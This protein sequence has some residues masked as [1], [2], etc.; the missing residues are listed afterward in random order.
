MARVFK[1]KY[2]T[3]RTSRGPDGKPVLITK[4]ATRGPRN[5]QTITT[6]QRAVI[7]DAAGRPIY[8]E[9]KRWSI[10]YTDAAGRKRTVPGYT[11][12]VATKQRAADIERSVARQREGIVDVDFE[13]KDK[14]LSKHIVDW[15]AD[16]ERSGRSPAYR[17]K[18]ASRVGR[19]QNELGWR[20]LA[21][22]RTDKV[23]SW[24]VRLSSDGLATRTVNHYLE[25]AS[26]FCNWCVSQSRMERNPLLNVAKA[27]VVEPRV[28]RRAATVKELSRLIASSPRRALVYVVATL[29]G[30]RRNEMKLLQWGDVVLEHDR[31]HIALRAE[32]TK[33]RRAD[34]VALNA[35]VA[36]R[37]RCAKPPGA[38]TA[39]RVFSS[40]P[41]SETFRRD[42]ERAGIPV[43]LDGKKLDFHALRVTHGTLLA[44]SGATIREAMEQMRHTDVRLTTKVYTDPRLIDTHRA[45]TRIPRIT[46]SGSAGEQLRAT[47]TDGQPQPDASR[48]AGIRFRDIP[49]DIGEEVTGRGQEGPK[50]ADSVEASPD[51]QNVVTPYEHSVYDENDQWR[52]G[53]SNPR[54]ATDPWMLLRV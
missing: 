25:A 53:E 42:L 2:P 12:K 4:V 48:A 32:T 7:R 51:R 35:E 19:M 9:S 54:P 24:L 39:D 8:K 46:S 38:G 41:K 20:G 10:E 44:T 43:V 5:G 21:S 40:I 14:P 26:A 37:L 33:S 27:P 17:N 16:L 29:T 31:P 30:L 11:D 23:T 6:R 28:R 52:R 3:M 34:T 47:G 15:L 49:R 1:S 22:I 45:V 13:H 18:L 36:E 50:M